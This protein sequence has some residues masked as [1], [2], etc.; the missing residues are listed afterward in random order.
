MTGSRPLRPGDPES[1]G[2]YT[3]TAFLGQGG[4]DSVYLGASSSG[5]RVAIK[6]LHARLAD[7]ASAVRRFRREAEAARR[8]AEFRTARVLEVRAVDTQPYFVS[9]YVDGPLLQHQVT[10]EGPLR[11]PR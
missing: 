2:P 6:L 8:V 3:L 4:Q 11:A 5:A 10:A 9:E 1:V 7:D